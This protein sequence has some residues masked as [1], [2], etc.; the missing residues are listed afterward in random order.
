[1]PLRVPTPRTEDN[2]LFLTIRRPPRSTLFPYTTLFRSTLCK[3]CC[4]IQHNNGTWGQIIKSDKSLSQMSRTQD[5]GSLRRRILNAK[6]FVCVFSLA[7]KYQIG[8]A[9]V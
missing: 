2:I 7:Q 8:R 1:M 6:T 4:C 9:H 5:Y 3:K